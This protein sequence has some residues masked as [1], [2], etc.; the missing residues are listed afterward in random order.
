VN[1]TFLGRSRPV[2]NEDLV[3]ALRWGH[4]EEA[5]QPIM[6][7]MI[8]LTIPDRAERIRRHLGFSEERMEQ[9]LARERGF[10]RDP[11]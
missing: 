9:E 10:F 5:L 3:T 6:H 11:G 4:V 2:T 8:A 1:R 7:V